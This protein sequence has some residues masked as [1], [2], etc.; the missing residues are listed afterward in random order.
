MNK[1]LPLTLALGVFVGSVAHGMPGAQTSSTQTTSAIEVSWEC[2]PNVSVVGQ[3]VPV[4][5]SY[6]QYRRKHTRGYYRRYRHYDWRYYAVP[7]SGY[8]YGNFGSSGLFSGNGLIV[9]PCEYGSYM[10]CSHGTCW[11]TCY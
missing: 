3:C 10:T 4:S 8:T 11:R 1:L 9:E 7:Y 5:G 2:R 6:S